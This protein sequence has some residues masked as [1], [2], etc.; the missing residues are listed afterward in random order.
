MDEK[1]K[2]RFITMEEQLKYLTSDVKELKYDVKNIPRM[3]EEKLEAHSCSIK[4]YLDN[5][6]ESHLRDKGTKMF[7]ARYMQTWAIPIL[8]ACI[9]GLTMWMFQLVLKS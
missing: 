4:A 5:S 6:V 9:G 7:A 8:F 3:L 2:E 1:L